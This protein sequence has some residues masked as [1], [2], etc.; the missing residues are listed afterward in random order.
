[1]SKLPTSRTI[2]IQNENKETFQAPAIN[3]ISINVLIEQIAYRELIDVEDV[4][5]VSYDSVGKLKFNEDYS[6]GAI[7]DYCSTL[8]EF[9]ESPKCF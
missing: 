4:L 7:E 8:E 5:T 3:G 2:T 1:M 9:K 6:C